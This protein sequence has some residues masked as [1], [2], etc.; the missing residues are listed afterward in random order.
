MNRLFKYCLGALV[1]F[2]FLLGLAAAGLRIAFPPAKRRTL[3]QEQVRT[4]FHREIQFDKMRVGLRGLT[5][6]RARLSEKPDFNRG[7]FLSIESVRVRWAWLP[8]L[9]HRLRLTQVILERPRITFIRQSDGKTYN[10]SDLFSPASGPGVPAFPTPLPVA[11]ASVPTR[12]SAPENR[13][14]WAWRVDQAHVKDGAFHLND[15]SPARQSLTLDS[16]QLRL[17]DSDAG[18][19]RGSMSAGEARN[20]FF[21]AQGLSLEWDLKG[22]DPAWIRTRG[23]AR[24]RQGPGHIVNPAALLASGKTAQ[25]LF[26]PLDSLNPN[27]VAS[28]GLPD[29]RR[30]TVQ[31]IAGDYRFDHGIVII[32]SFQVEGRPV[33]LNAKG[34]IELRT[35][36]LDA[37]ATLRSDPESTK[38]EMDA[39]LHLQGTL[40]NPKVTLV[41]LRAKKIR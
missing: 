6:E 14:N 34:I 21:E 11:G 41:S 29:L 2:V 38:K 33:G 9:R 8:L 7:L 19:L 23:W 31:S 35:G 24:L 16:I 36:A 27:R 20:A 3:L 1:L 12:Q 32:D 39:R 22:V 30:W 5:L 15:L 25:M 17:Q 28:L 26:L 18:R 37:Y 4:R 40:A 10:I 13:K